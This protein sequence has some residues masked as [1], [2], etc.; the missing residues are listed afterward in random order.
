MIERCLVELPDT[1]CFL[2]V[3]YAYLRHADL[4]GGGKNTTVAAAPLSW[5]TCKR[6]PPAHSLSPRLVMLIGLHNAC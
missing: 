3:L 5:D 1:A 2:L 4:I 6:V